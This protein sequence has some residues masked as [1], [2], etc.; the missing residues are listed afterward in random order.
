[1]YS[2][3]PS[4]TTSFHYNIKKRRTKS[5]NVSQQIFLWLRIPTKGVLFRHGEKWRGVDRFSCGETRVEFCNH[6]VIE[7]LAALGIM[8]TKLRVLQRSVEH[9]RMILLRRVLNRLLIMI[10]GISRYLGWQMNNISVWCINIC[11][12]RCI[13]YIFFLTY[14]FNISS[15]IIHDVV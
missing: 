12:H 4:K 5:W 9:H 7:R 13:I 3:K 1:M 11:I 15:Y 8:K 10:R 14:I 2:V 6:Q